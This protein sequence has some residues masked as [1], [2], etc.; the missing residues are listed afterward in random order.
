[1]SSEGG[2]AMGTSEQLN[3]EGKG[4]HGICSIY[5]YRRIRDTRFRRGKVEDGWRINGSGRMEK[6]RPV[7]AYSVTPIQRGIGGV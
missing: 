1:M 6:K 2:S 3:W 4:A 5:R 7:R